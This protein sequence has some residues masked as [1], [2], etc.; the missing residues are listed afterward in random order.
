MGA[1]GPK[2]GV[3]AY[4]A[5]R[6]AEAAVSPVIS[7]ILMVAITVV[8]AA[9]AFVLVAGVGQDATEPAPNVGLRIDDVLD[10]LSVT[11]ADQKADWNRIAVAIA[12]H[13]CG[14]CQIF[15]GSSAGPISEP[16]ASDG[17]EIIGNTDLISTDRP[18]AGGDFLGFCR[19]G[20]VVGPVEI[21]LIDVVSNAVVG[22][23]YGFSEVE[24]CP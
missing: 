18:I 1:P 10:Q 9:T 5:F 14:A 4:A 6:K 24:A 12:S 2:H 19:V 17:L 22:T 15:V 20:G 3:A 8:L 23:T 11:Q 16:G 13:D 21:K 7:T